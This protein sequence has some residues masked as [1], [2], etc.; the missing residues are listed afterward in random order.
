M[1]KRLEQTIKKENQ[2]AKMYNIIDDICC[3]FI[4]VYMFML[5]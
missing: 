5:F 4:C 1:S 2:M 3:I